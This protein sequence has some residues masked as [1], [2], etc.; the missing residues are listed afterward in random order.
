MRRVF[1]FALLLLLS[2]CSR[3]MRPDWRFSFDGTGELFIGRNKLVCI[4]V[5]PKNIVRLPRGQYFRLSGGYAIFPPQV[6][7]SKMNAYYL[8]RR[9]KDGLMLTGATAERSKD[10]LYFRR[11]AGKKR[12]VFKLYREE[13]RSAGKH[14]YIELDS[15]GIVKVGIGDLS[16]NSYMQ[17]FLTMSEHTRK[18][19]IAYVNLISERRREKQAEA[20]SGRSRGVAA[21]VYRDSVYRY[22]GSCCHP[23]ELP[24]YTILRNDS[25][26]AYQKLCLE[27]QRYPHVPKAIDY[28][29]AL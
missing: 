5:G 1:P 17:Y 15:L 21:L 26:I 7:H 24:M 28:P 8:I 29:I 16:D 10:T 18:K 9:S 3:E 22:D 19:C 6:F 12:P 2:S 20:G 4:G 23:L 25:G 13:I 14:Y 11:L 27:K